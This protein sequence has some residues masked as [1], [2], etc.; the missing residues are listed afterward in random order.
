MLLRTQLGLRP[1]IGDG[2]EVN[3]ARFSRPPTQAVGFRHRFCVTFSEGI[4]HSNIHPRHTRIPGPCTWY[5]YIT[6]IVARR[7]RKEG[8]DGGKGLREYSIEVTWVTW[9][10]VL[11][12][13]HSTGLQRCGMQETL[14]S[15]RSPLRAAATQSI[16]SRTLP[17]TSQ[18]LCS[19][20]HRRHHHPP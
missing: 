1:I 7:T 2:G 5:A 8:I 18:P 11:D 20:N 12:G 10:Q 16:A 15:R 14:P 4:P 6:G 17:T 13:R 19:I 9:K 3:A